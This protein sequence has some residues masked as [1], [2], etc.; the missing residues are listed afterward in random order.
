MKIQLFAIFLLLILT[1]YLAFTDYNLSSDLSAAKKDIAEKKA[2]AISLS[3][4]IVQ[5]DLDISKLSSDLDSTE[6]KLSDSES[7]LNSANSKINDLNSVLD[8]TEKDFNKLDTQLQEVQ[9]SIDSSVQ[10]F[11]TNS[12]LPPP[13]EVGVKEYEYRKF[14]EEID[15]SCIKNGK[16]NLGCI[17]YSMKN[18][19]KFDYKTENQDKLS[20]LVES[21]KKDG[22]DCEDF[23]LLFKAIL[24]KYRLNG[25]T[26]E[27]EAWHKEDG[28]KYMIYKNPDYYYYYQN[29]AGISIG[30]NSN[31]AYIICY[32]TKN[33]FPILEGHCTIAISPVKITKNE[34]VV[35]LKDAKMFEPQDGAYKGIAGQ[36]LEICNN[37]EIG[38]EQEVGKIV[39]V[40]TDSDIYRFSDGNWTSYGYYKELASSLK[41]RIEQR[42]I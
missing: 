5:K 27:L 29:S 11:K 13:I 2:E 36:D 9:D 33:D 26:L 39:F 38:C 17:S 25:E 12:K 14:L 18:T 24:S 6:K 4:Q 40:L 21:I 32:V 23:S 8:Q 7:K 37:G 1:A 42:K 41:L 34:E 20:T 15:G 16:I 3:G 35:N 22:G 28:S 31:N 19:L 30:S 10:W